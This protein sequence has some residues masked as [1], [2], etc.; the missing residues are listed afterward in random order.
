MWGVKW[1]TNVQNK[2]MKA[3]YDKKGV[4]VFVY[5]RQGW[6]RFWVEGWWWICFSS[7]CTGSWN[8]YKIR[9][10]SV[11]RG[12]SCVKRP[13]I[14]YVGVIIIVRLLLPLCANFKGR[15][16]NINACSVTGFEQLICRSKSIR[17]YIGKYLAYR[18]Q[19]FT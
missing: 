4:R 15:A 9:P 7:A 8:N 19:L 11:L 2:N 10:P 16:K 18:F 5:T 12:V 1:Y 6:W 17:S 3:D 13:L 14:I